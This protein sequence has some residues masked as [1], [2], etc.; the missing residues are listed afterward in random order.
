MDNRILAAYGVLGAVAGVAIGYAVY[1][2]GPGIKFSFVDWLT[3]EAVGRPTDALLW[4]ALGALAGAAV[5]YLRRA[6]SN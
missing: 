5:A 3:H 4:A 2:L 1:A 6:N